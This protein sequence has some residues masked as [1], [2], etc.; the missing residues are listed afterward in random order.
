MSPSARPWRTSTRPSQMSPVSMLRRLDVAVADD[1]HERTLG[2]EHDRGRRHARGRALR[3]LDGAAGEAADAQAWVVAEEDAHAAEPCRLV[4]LRRH[5]THGAGDVA[6][7][8]D[9]DLAPSAPRSSWRARSRSPPRRAPPRRAATM[10]NIGS[11][12]PEAM[13]PMRAMRRLTRPSAGA[14]TSVLS[15]R[16]CSSRRCASTWAFSASASL[17]PSRAATSWACELLAAGSRWS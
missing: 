4:D 2:V 10:R 14:I 13:P 15:R 5:E 12:T 1:L 7:A 11:A 6:D 16:H 9:V 3:G 17:S 8:G